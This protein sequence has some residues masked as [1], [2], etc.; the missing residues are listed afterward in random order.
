[1]PQ[2]FQIFS[3]QGADVSSL[4][5]HGMPVD[6][7]GHMDGKTVA[8][9]RPADGVCKKEH[10]SFSSALSHAK[11]GS[12]PSG[13][14]KKGTSCKTEQK[15]TEPEIKENDTAKT[16]APPVSIKESADDTMVFSFLLSVDGNTVV[17]VMN[18][19]SDIKGNNETLGTEKGLCIYSVKSE[20]CKQ[21]ALTGVMANNDKDFHADNVAGNHM[22]KIPEFKGLEHMSSLKV[23]GLKHDIDKNSADVLCKISDKNLS[24]KTDDFLILQQEDQYHQEEKPSA[25]FGMLAEDKADTGAN[26]LT[27]KNGIISGAPVN[28]GEVRGGAG[29][30]TKQEQISHM[31][32][33]D[34]VM[35]QVERAVMSMNNGKKAIIINLKPDILGKLRVSI[36]TNH[37]QVVVKIFA[38]TALVKHIIESN[39]N[40][41]KSDLQNQG[42]QV[43]QFEV[44]DRGNGQQKQGEGGYSMY[45]SESDLWSDGDAGFVQLDQRALDPVQ[46]G[47]SLTGMSLVNFFA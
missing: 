15:E 30:S 10:A 5:G 20:S 21:V 32:R 47:R 28:T 35:D 33:Q 23:K 2:S 13:P 22:L 45:E 46:T 11:K 3:A 18:N 41:F 31:V 34:N 9:H 43:D 6:S 17:P 40:Q 29:I 36:S 24:L 7:K 27:A 1:M 42:M 38:D 4:K 37:Q 12:Q 8:D 44:F 16:D 19:L 39:L 14:K 25:D 26:T